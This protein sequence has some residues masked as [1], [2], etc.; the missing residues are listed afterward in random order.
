[1]K[2]TI[3]LPIILSIIFCNVVFAEMWPPLNEYV[4][5]CVLIVKCRVEIDK[6]IVKY[7]VLENW[8]GKYSPDLFYE[9]PEDGY[10]S[11][12]TWHGNED[13][14]DGKDVIFFFT[15]KNNPSWAKGKISAH[16]TAFSVKNNKIVYAST[17]RVLRE[18]YTIEEFK[19]EII[20]IAEKENVRRSEK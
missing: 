13:P 4:K 3:I 17:N 5:S 2:K 18:E 10:V 14:K 11:T 20:S 8:K 19:K 7:R 15:T 12:N 9:K 1:M 16:S 6:D